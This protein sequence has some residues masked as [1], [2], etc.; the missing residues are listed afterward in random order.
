MEFFKEKQRRRTGS[1]KNYAES[2]KINTAEGKLEISIL[3]YPL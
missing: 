3:P 1:E 2:I